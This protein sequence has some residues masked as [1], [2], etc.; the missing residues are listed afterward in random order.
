[1]A[2]G[3]RTGL[4]K[5]TVW[6]LPLGFATIILFIA[7]ISV[8]TLYFEREWGKLNFSLFFPR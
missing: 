5:H 6:I 3:R 7:F 1:M 2:R 8:I 4:R